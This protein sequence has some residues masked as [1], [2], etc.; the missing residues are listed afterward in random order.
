MPKGQRGYAKTYHAPKVLVALSKKLASLK[1]VSYH[2][3]WESKYPEHDSYNLFEG[4][5]YLEF[6]ETD[7][8]Y[9]L[10]R[11]HSRGYQL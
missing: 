1:S 3:S 4:A 7:K 11:V 8:R 5:G 9:R 6:N 10:L 2:Y